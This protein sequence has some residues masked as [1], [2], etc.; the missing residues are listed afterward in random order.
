[1]GMVF[2]AQKDFELSFQTLSRAVEINP[3]EAYLWYNRGLSARFTSRTALSLRDFEQ[4]VRL[5]GQGKMVARFQEEEI[6]ARQIAESERV[7]RGKDFTLDQ[8]IEQQAL[9]Q[10]GNTLSMQGKWPEAEACFR[11]SIAM[12]DCL[13]QPWGNLGICLAMQKR[14]D[15]AEV[16]Y[17]RALEIDPKYERAKEHLNNLANM[18]AHPEDMPEFAITSPFMGVKT[19]FTITKE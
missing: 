15:E 18:R 8:L 10:R 7:L 14:F 3:N 1:M 12:G 19:S 4:A 13:P 6:F 9:F 2:A 11:Q 17:K 16:A 5:A